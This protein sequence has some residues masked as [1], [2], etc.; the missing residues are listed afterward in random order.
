MEV[1]KKKE[2][3]LWQLI[4]FKENLAESTNKL[5]VKEVMGIFVRSKIQTG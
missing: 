3:K 1:K 5:R 2:V 4:K